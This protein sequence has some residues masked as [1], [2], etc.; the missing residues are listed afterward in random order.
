MA[1]A[2]YGQGNGWFYGRRVAGGIIF[3]FIIEDMG[4]CDKGDTNGW[5]ID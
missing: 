3:A 2:L 5:G 1:M 4:E